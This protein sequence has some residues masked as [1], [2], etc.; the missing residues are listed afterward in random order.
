M[1]PEEVFAEEAQEEA[2][3]SEDH[4]EELQSDAHFHMRRGDDDD[5]HE[6]DDESSPL[7]SPERH[8][9]A[10]TPL[11]RARASYERAINEP[12]TG[13]QG[14]SDAPW[15]SRPSVCLADTLKLA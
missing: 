9:A 10:K 8:R 1:E 2:F 15:Y 6:S 14:S 3:L 7:M 4:S 11:A 5:D 13:A 12:W